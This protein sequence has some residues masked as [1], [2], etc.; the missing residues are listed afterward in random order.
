MFV[1]PKTEITEVKFYGL[2]YWIVG[3][4]SSRTPAQSLRVLSYVNGLKAYVD[5]T[6]T[7]IQSNGLTRFTGVKS[8]SRQRVL[9]CLSKKVTVGDPLHVSKFIYGQTALTLEAP[10][11][12]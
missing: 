8:L 1:S 12:E 7:K 11:F 2:D 3:S 5:A 4:P 6:P 10:G 9:E